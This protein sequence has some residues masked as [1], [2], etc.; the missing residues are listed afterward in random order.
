MDNIN[1]QKIAYIADLIQSRRKTEAKDRVSNPEFSKLNSESDLQKFFGYK[2][3]TAK[4]EEAIAFGLQ[5]LTIWD[6]GFPTLLKNSPDAPLVLY[7]RGTIPTSDPMVAIVGSRGADISAWR[8]AAKLGRELADAGITIVSGL[9]KGIDG[10]AHNGALESRNPYP[11]IAVL[12]HG[13][14]IIYPRTHEKLAQN[15]VE[16][17]GAIFSEYPLG[18]PPFKHQFLERNRIVAGL[19]TATIV[20]QAG[21]RSGAL[22]TAREALD[23]GRDLFVS[24]GPPDDDRYSGSHKLLKTGA[25]MITS[26]ED[27]L[28]LFPDFKNKKTGSSDLIK[29]TDSEKLI[30]S[31]LK[32]NKPIFLSDLPTATNLTHQ[33]LMLAISSLELSRTIQ[34]L[35]GERLILSGI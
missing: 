29:Y 13:L 28:E 19:S 2:V 12:A 33:D 20:I 17:G 31:A 26:V 24:P 21:E 14:D 1:L 10:A 30:L 22:V 8:F 25:Y 34:I 32:G 27:V 4:I 6:E 35:P 18:I 16:Q 11:T 23:A 15:I 9:A 3:S 7:I 5:V